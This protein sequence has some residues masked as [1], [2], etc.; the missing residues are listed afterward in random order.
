MPACLCLC[1]RVCSSTFLS[2]FCFVRKNRVTFYLNVKRS[3]CFP[4][5]KMKNFP[6]KFTTFIYTHIR[7]SIDSIGSDEETL[8]P[9]S[10]LADGARGSRYNLPVFFDSKLSLPLPHLLAVLL[11]RRRL[12]MLLLRSFCCGFHPLTLRSF[13]TDDVLL[14]IPPSGLLWRPHCR[15]RK[16]SRGRIT[17]HNLYRWYHRGRFGENLNGFPFVKQPLLAS[18]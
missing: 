9:P 12:K 13:Q 8:S 2:N 14:C 1:A 16:K 7:Q 6:L 17:H 4:D 10:F 15:R 5:Q 11:S 18:L 3:S